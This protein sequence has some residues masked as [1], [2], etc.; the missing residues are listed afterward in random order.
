VAEIEKRVRNGKIRWVA[1]YF[2]PD[3]KRRGETFDRKIDA[4]QRLAQIKVS[5]VSGSYVDPAR[6][7]ITMA[8]MANIW[9]ETQG[10][11]KPSTLARYQGIV[12]KHIKP[13]WGN[14]PISKITHAD[15]A[16]W[17]SSIR[18]SAASVQ[19]IHRVMYLILELAARD[20]RIP[21]NPAVGTQLRFDGRPVDQRP[22]R[23]DAAVTEAIE[24]VLGKAEPFAVR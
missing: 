11:L 16:K 4:Q 17:I 7:K 9:L 3:G 22:Y 5:K 2:D 8:A 20:G 6:G 23:C 13:N 24:H 19:Y 12:D 18:L 10:H 21:R 15:V 1:R 14:F